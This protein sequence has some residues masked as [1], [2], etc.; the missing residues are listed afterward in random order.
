M[1]EQ[2]I[3]PVAELTRETLGN[4]VGRGTI[5]A[6]ILDQSCISAVE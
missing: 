3:K 4:E 2:G 6:S 5:F 1:V